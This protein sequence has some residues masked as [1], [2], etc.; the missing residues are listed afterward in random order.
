MDI[1]FGVIS[2]IIGLIVFYFL[3]LQ[4]YKLGQTIKGK[5]PIIY[6]VYVILWSL[7]LAAVVLAGL[8]IIGDN[9]ESKKRQKRMSELSAIVESKP[10]I[11][12]T[13]KDAV[14]SE[15]RSKGYTDYEIYIAFEKSPYLKESFEKA[16][17]EGGYTDSDIAKHYGL[18]I[19]K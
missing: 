13:N 10:Y 12:K 4:F 17:I 5:Y 16:K 11:N 6:R 14:V 1:I 3:G 15:L 7:I 19:F 2:T 18:D 8:T 9:I